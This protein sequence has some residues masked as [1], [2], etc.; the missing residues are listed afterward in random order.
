MAYKSQLGEDEAFSSIRQHLF[1]TV[2]VSYMVGRLRVQP[3]TLGTHKNE[4]QWGFLGCYLQDRSP[5]YEPN[6]VRYIR[7]HHFYF[8][9][10]LF[11]TY[12]INGS[13]P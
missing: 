6:E 1:L 7:Y 13:K 9:L 8:A 12:H 3:F 5:F 10:V 2:I 11:F 4:R